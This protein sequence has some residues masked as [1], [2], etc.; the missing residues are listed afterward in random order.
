MDSEKI[1]MEEIEKWMIM[2][3]AKRWFSMGKRSLIGKLLRSF[4]VVIFPVNILTIILI[5]LAVHSYERQISDLYQYQLDI[6]AKTVENE[7]ESMNQNIRRNLTVDKL[8][9]LVKGS[10]TDSTIDAIKFTDLLNGSEQRDDF[11]AMNFVWDRK[12]EI[13]SF[14]NAKK[15]YSENVKNVLEQEITNIETQKTLKENRQEKVVVSDGHAFLLQIYDYPFFSLGS[16]YDVELILKGVYEEFDESSGKIY[17]AD[18][19]GNL[20]AAGMRDKY[21]CGE[22]LGNLAEWKV[23]R[24]WLVSH[25]LG[26]GELSLVYHISDN[27]YMKGLYLVLILL[28]VFCI[29]SLAAVP[30]LWSIEKKLVVKPLTGLCNAMKE[31]EEGDFDYQIEEKTGSYQMD[32]LYYSFNR[33]TKELQHMITESYGREIERLQIESVN[34]KLQVNQHMLLNF[35]NTI[36]SLSRVGKKE[37]VEEFTLLLMNYFRYVL[38][39]NI[40]LVTIQEE[41]QFVQDYLKLQKVRYPKSFHLAYS[42]EEGAENLRIPQLLIENFVENSIK[43][44]LIIGEEIEIIVNIRT[45]GESL[46]VSICDTGNGMEKERAEQLQRGEIVED[47]TGKHIGIWNCIRRLKYYYGDQ[48]ELTISSEP[49]QGTQVWI[50]MRKEALHKDEISRYI[51]HSESEVMK[52]EKT[53]EYSAGR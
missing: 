24:T 12:K 4:C 35:L 51:Y 13:M 18:S 45:E 30:V 14:S 26:F 37:E 25:E 47:Q 50:R 36:Y 49:G 33:M 1:V 43:Y 21:E 34:L 32:F 39:Q 41:M 23:Q 17:L 40:G 42:V 44:G 5:A 7:M 31:V 16:V 3:R 9:V 8:L 15:A 29:V 48:Q 20:L 52:G 28:V 22:D 10:E 38:R 27:D 2:S 6:Y 19:D 46:I 11:R 53:H